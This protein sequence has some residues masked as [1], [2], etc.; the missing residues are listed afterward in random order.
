MNRTWSDDRDGK[1][2]T[3]EAVYVM[4]VRKEGDPIAMMGPEVPLRISFRHGDEHFETVAKLDQP[5]TKLPDF[6]VAS[7]LDAARDPMGQS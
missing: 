6:A 4:P 1:D 5:L 7:L 2:W 3:I